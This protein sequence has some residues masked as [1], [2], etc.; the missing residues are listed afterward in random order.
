MAYEVNLDLSG[1]PAQTDMETR[2]ITVLQR[3]RSLK[4]SR[5]EGEDG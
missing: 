2:R 4:A 5:G 3:C 1:F